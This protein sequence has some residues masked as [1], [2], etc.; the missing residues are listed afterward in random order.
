MR[1]VR[2]KICGITSEKDLTATVTAGADAVG[3]VVNVPSSP[4]NL[5]VD[6]ARK[7]IRTTPIF[8]ESVAV[9][10]PGNIDS[11]IKIYEELKPKAI[12]V[13]GENV[14]N[15]SQ[16][17]KTILN[18][19][20]IRAISAKSDSVIKTASEAS[21]SFDAILLDTY[22]NG[23]NGGTGTIHNWEISKQVRQAIS[24]KP[25]I[26]AGGLNPQNVG[27]AIQ[28]VQPYA[29]DVSTGVE[30]SPG[31]KDPKKVSE[32]IESVRR[33]ET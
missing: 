4:R 26:L 6:K 19:H 22:A 28:M 27:R 11:L 8:V 10:V 33:T 25:L 31:I 30:S 17:P 7:L 18:T 29:V 24:P 32:F 13:H 20:L 23:K 1:R 12:Q 3:F 15:F 5:T 9:T 2:V 16:I 14:L 21:N